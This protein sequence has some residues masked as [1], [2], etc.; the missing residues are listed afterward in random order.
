M[1]SF[2][3]IGTALLYMS[4]VLMGVLS[5]PNVASVLAPAERGP[6]LT[7]QARVRPSI[8]EALADDALGREFGAHEIVI[9]E[10]RAR[11][12]AEVELGKVAMQVLFLAMLVSNR[13]LEWARGRPFMPRAS[14]RG[15]PN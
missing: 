6:Y 11:V 3:T 2:T 7:F 15:P 8:G 1:S 10:R 9:T 13:L 4:S 14:K 12:V 5:M